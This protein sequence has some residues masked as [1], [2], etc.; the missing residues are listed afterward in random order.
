MQCIFDLI[1]APTGGP[2]MI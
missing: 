2:Q 1:K